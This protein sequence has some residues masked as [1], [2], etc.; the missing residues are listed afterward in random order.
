MKNFKLCLWCCDCEFCCNMLTDGTGYQLGGG[1]RWY[2]IGSFKFPKMDLWIIWNHR[3]I[4]SKT[5]FVSII[6][7]CT[8]FHDSDMRIKSS[9]RVRIH[10]S[11]WLVRF[12]LVLPRPSALNSPQKSKTS[13]FQ[14]IDIDVLKEQ[15]S[16]TNGSVTS[17]NQWGSDCV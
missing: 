12:V 13:K 2:A 4:K 3:T 14:K 6:G 11:Y 16:S 10:N 15:F 5:P 8:C 17:F 1:G 7:I 9:L